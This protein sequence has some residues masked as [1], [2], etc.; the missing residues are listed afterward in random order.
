MAFAN[1][2]SSL[3]CLNE[4]AKAP[5]QVDSTNRCGAEGGGR[6]RKTQSNNTG[7]HVKKRRFQTNASGDAF[8]ESHVHK[9]E[10]GHDQHGKP[11]N[12]GGRH[13]KGQQYRNNSNSSK[14]KQQRQTRSMGRGR[15]DYRDGRKPMPRKWERGVNNIAQE[16]TRYMSQEFKEQ[17][18]LEVDGRL[19]CRH[20]IMGRCIKA[21]TCQLEHVQA[22]NDL[23]KAGCKYYFIGVCMKGDSCP[24]MHKSFPCKFFHRRGKCSQQENCRFSHEPLTDVTEKLLDEAIKRDIEFYEQKKKSE[25]ES[26]GEPV[27]ESE[28]PPAIENPD[29]PVELLRP[30]F[31]NSADV[32]EQTSVHQNEDVGSDADPPQGPTLS[33]P[34]Q[35]EPVCYSVEAVLGPQLSRPLFSF[36]TKPESQEPPSVPPSSSETSSSS[37][38]PNE[39]PYSVDA[40]LRSFKSVESSEFADNTKTVPTYSNKI[41][42]QNQHL[43]E[44]SKIEM[45]R[46][47]NMLSSLPR[48]DGNNH[49]PKVSSRS[50]SSPKHP[51][52]FKPHVSVLTPDFPSLTK[53]SVGVK[54]FK[55]SVQN[56]QSDLKLDPSSEGFSQQSS[57]SGV[58]LSLADGAMPKPACGLLGFN[59][60]RQSSETKGNRTSNTS[61]LS[62]FASPLGGT[63]APP[64]QSAAARSS[65]P[66]CRLQPAG[67][68]PSIRREKASD[69]AAPLP[70]W[71]TTDERPT[72]RR[73]VSPRGSSSSETESACRTQQGVPHASP[74]RVKS[75]GS[76]LKTLFVSLGPYQEDTKRQNRALNT[77][78]EGVNTEKSSAECSSTA[79]KRKRKNRQ[80]KNNKTPASYNQ[81]SDKPAEQQT[82]TTGPSNP[83]SPGTTAVQVGESGILT[84]PS[85]PAAPL[86]QRHTQRSSEEG[87]GISGSAALGLFKELFRTLNSSAFD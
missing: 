2:F 14:N 10:R 54:G 43:K 16:E 49:L 30:S 87:D 63:T 72:L 31:Y 61:F 4:A 74:P 39:A 82:D 78:P 52:M 80:W 1:L 45:K 83:Y 32:E 6:K 53:P 28:A 23:I 85:E 27:N 46:S 60:P 65:P 25:Q 71:V 77:N 50:E 34:D 44:N 57:F 79:Q 40:F 29:I 18:A 84:V 67:G 38:N 58:S 22:Y 20:F 70:H 33:S 36:F 76:V 8:K 3:P 21:D 73:M 64:S 17:N 56:S 75:E 41:T 24:Y 9:R 26:L 81:T 37:V 19:L 62:L 86:M 68:A 13:H 59:K 35:K 69:V 47:E 55:S 12:R 15:N 5:R 48:G 11:Q 7:S 51:S 42:D 66:P